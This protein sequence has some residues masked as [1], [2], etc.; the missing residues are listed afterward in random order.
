VRE[1]RYGV[2]GQDGGDH[3]ERWQPRVDFGCDFFGELHS[4]YDFCFLSVSGFSAEHAV[5]FS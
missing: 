4:V 2:E 1:G 3:K 5:T